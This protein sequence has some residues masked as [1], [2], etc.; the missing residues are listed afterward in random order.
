MQSRAGELTEELIGSAES[1]G[2]IVLR[3]DPSDAAAY[4][5]R[6]AE[7]LE[8]KTYFVPTMKCWTR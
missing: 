4:V 8:L 2:W 5:R 3:A 1:A 6:V 7:T